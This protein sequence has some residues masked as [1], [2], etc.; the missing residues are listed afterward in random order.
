MAAT[1]RKQRKQPA[2]AISAADAK[3]AQNSGYIPL[4]IR[5]KAWWEGVDAEKLMLR[6]GKARRRK[7][8]AEIKIDQPVDDI[9]A[10]KTDFELL[11]SIR[12]R[13][14]GKDQIVPGG[15][16]YV[17]TFL[18][19]A[20]LKP[21]TLLLDLAA[22]LGGCGRAIAVELDAVVEG[23][24]T[25]EAVAKIGAARAAHLALDKQAPIS[26]YLAHNPFL[27]VDRYDCVYAH[28][29]FFR[30]LD[31]GNLFTEVRKSLKE[32]GDFIFSDLIYGN[33]GDESAS[34]IKAWAASETEV[35]DPWT[36]DR[37]RSELAEIGF[38]IVAFEDETALYQ[39]MIRE[40]WEA[41]A[42]TLDDRTINRRFV[43]IMMHEAKIWQ[44][45]TAAIKAGHLR[46]LR[47]H[48]RRS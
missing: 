42:G 22:G 12:E 29:A 17:S 18:D 7:S 16:D 15:P 41:F 26:H 43:D 46:F 27:R 23:L 1:A 33:A 32:E 47:V 35:P 3:R 6:Q 5:F 13:V 38:E 37:Y 4:K 24:E 40:G 44:C 11:M 19:G 31:K 14:W 39:G 10:N 48:A 30:I 20:K 2:A 8:S 9:D 21:G 25:D 34:A 45:R 36:A 28:E